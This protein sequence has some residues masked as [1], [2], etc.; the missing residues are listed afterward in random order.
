MEEPGR[1]H[2]ATLVRIRQPEGSF[3]FTLRL[4]FLMGLTV[5]SEEE[6]LRALVNA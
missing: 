1:F 2:D 5:I 4:G 3:L 6:A